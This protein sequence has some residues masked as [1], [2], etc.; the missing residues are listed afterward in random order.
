MH[1]FRKFPWELFFFYCSSNW[2]TLPFLKTPKEKGNEMRNIQGESPAHSTGFGRVSTV[3]WDKLKTCQDLLSKTE[4]FPEHRTPD[5]PL[6]M[7]WQLRLSKTGG[8]PTLISHKTKSSQRH[9]LIFCRLSLIELYLSHA[10]F[11]VRRLI[12]SYPLNNVFRRSGRDNSSHDSSENAC[13]VVK[14]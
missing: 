9:C 3:T 5:F 12:P 6:Y 1:K 4:M 14:F 7:R 11:Q 8:W 10:K 2:A 13:W